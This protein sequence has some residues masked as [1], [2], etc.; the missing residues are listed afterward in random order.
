ME[1]PPPR[2]NY[3]TP[4]PEG[5]SRFRIALWWLFC[6]FLG[7]FAAFFFV[8][9]VALLWIPPFSNGPSRS[10]ADKML[11]YAAMPFGIGF[12]VASYRWV[13]AAKKCGG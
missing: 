11:P 2:L 4:P 13:R 8:S 3:E 9:A 10:V 5:E 1:Q 12:G 7:L 6:L